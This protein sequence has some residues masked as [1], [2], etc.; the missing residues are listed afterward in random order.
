M[1][2]GGGGEWYLA[3]VVFELGWFIDEMGCLDCG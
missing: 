2:F 3:S 1:L